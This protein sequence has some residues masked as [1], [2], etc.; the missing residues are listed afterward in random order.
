MKKMTTLLITAFAVFLTGCSY[1]PHPSFV[2]NRDKAYLQARSIPPLKIPPGI[3]STKID[4]YYPVSDQTY[5]T[6]MTDVSLLPPGL[7]K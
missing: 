1:L 5:P 4:T 3:S 6:S 7:K 2:Q